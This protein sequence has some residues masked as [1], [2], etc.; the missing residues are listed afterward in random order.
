[1]PRALDQVPVELA[2]GEWT[3]GVRAGL[4]DGTNRIASLVEEDRGIAGHGLDEHVVRELPLEHD[5]GELD[6]HLLPGVVVDAGP[7]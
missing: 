7:D 1:M 3:A 4:T 6:R 5:L 2:L